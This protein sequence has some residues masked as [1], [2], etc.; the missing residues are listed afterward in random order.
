VSILILTCMED[1]S[2]QTMAKFVH[3]FLM[4]VCMAH[5]TQFDSVKNRGTQQPQAA[6]RAVGVSPR[7]METC[8]S[9]DL[10]TS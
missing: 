6:M 5:L 8:I 10:K 4:P 2:E 9:P 7:N 3:E 1:S